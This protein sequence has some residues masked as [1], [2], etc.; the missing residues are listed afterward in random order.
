MIRFR[1]STNSQIELGAVQ[2]VRGIGAGCLGFP[3]QTAVQSAAKHEHVAAITACYLLVCSSLSLH[4]SPL[5]I[6]TSSLTSFC[7]SRPACS[8]SNLRSDAPA[9]SLDY[10]AG[11]IGSAIGGGI[12]TAVVPGKIE[13][14]MGNPA[15]AASAYR[16][17]ITFA[18]TWAMGTPERIAISRAHD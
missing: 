13:Q 11:G 10:L 15:L 12:W 8:C 16:D 1:T 6:L 14:Y 17:P 5:A 4:I 7:L 3:T 2:I 18:R 9:A